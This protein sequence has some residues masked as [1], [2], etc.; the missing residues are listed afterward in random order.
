MER[1]TKNIVPR[2]QTAKLHGHTDNLQTG[3]KFCLP[4]YDLSVASTRMW[5]QQLVLDI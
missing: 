4:S 5:D 2:I 3:V 1:E